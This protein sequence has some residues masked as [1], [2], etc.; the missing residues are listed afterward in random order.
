[1]AVMNS[2]SLLVRATYTLAELL[3][4]EPDALA[5]V[6]NG[7]R[8]TLRPRYRRTSARTTGGFSEHSAWEFFL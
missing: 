1:M 6:R 5:W 2:T 8:E 4:G 7:L 3:G